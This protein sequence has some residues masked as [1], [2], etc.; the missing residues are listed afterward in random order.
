ML[1]GMENLATLT[2]R[3]TA[4]AAAGEGRSGAAQ[5]RPARIYAW[6]RALALAVLACLLWGSL[7]GVF[8]LGELVGSHL[9]APAVGTAPVPTL[10]GAQADP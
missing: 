1:E 8:R 7:W 10:D 6:R 2:T 3:G 5:P 9:V 4:L